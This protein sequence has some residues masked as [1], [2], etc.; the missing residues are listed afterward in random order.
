MREARDTKLAPAAPDKGALIDA[1]LSAPGA[2]RSGQAGV[3][4]R[5]RTNEGS[6]PFGCVRETRGPSCASRS[7][8]LG[9]PR[10]GSSARNEL[11]P[12]QLAEVI[13]VA[14][15][16]GHGD[17]QV[18]SRPSIDGVGSLRVDHRVGVSP[19]CGRPIDVD[20]HRA[21]AVGRRRSWPRNWPGRGTRGEQRAAQTGRA[22]ADEGPGGIEA[23]LK[24][25]MPGK[26]RSLSDPANV[27]RKDTAWPTR[28]AA[29][30]RR[31]DVMQG[32]AGREQNLTFQRFELR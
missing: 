30:R 28:G 2:G 22:G 5:L 8:G 3:T 13:G 25:G 32:R 31:R 16:P 14:V 24:W 18:A 29:A 26:L 19:R 11:H 10:H 21:A 7:E 1:C 12:C 20:R 27:P 9:F 4:L 23:E 15:G 17:L 6:N